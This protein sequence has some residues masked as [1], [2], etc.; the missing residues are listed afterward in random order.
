MP[1]I[2]ILLAL[3]QSGSLDPVTDPAYGPDGRIAASI[4][5][6]IWVLSA[7]RSRWSQ[8]TDGP[9]WDRQPAWYRDGSAL[10]FVSDRSGSPDL[11]VLRLE[12]SGRPTEPPERLTTSPQWDHQPTAG[13]N[14]SIVFVRG[15][16]PA[17]RLWIRTADGVER[18]LTRE[19]GSAEAW[20]AF[21]PQGDRVAYVSQ[22]AGEW[23]LRIAWIGRDSSAT[24]V[25]DRPI[26]WPAWS[27][28]GERL[29]FSTNGRTPGL[30]VTD[31]RGNYVN[32]IAP[33]AAQS[34]WSPDGKTLV[35]AKLAPPPPG[36]NG[37]PDRFG[38]RFTGELESEGSLAWVPAPAPPES[39]TEIA[40]PPR[41]EGT[42]RNLENFE[43]FWD[44][45]A[46]LYYSGR[47]REPLERWTALKEKYLPKARAASSESEL[48]SVFYAMLKERPHYRTPARGR[49]AV[50]SAHPVATAAGLEILEKGG[51]AVDAAVAVSFALGVVEPDASGIGGYGQMLI[52]L[53]GAPEPVLIEF[54]ARAPEEAGLLNAALTENGDYPDDGPVLANVPGLVAGM[55]LA[56]RRYGSGKL[57][58]EELLEPAIRAAERG[59]EV[60]DAL[61]TT[62]FLEQEHFRKY[63]ASR[64]LFLPGDRPLA[65]GDTLKNPDLAATLRRIAAG[66]AA[67]FY[68][69][70]TARKL[71]ADLRGQGNAIRLED[72]ARYYAAVRPA[73]GTTYRGYR[74]FSSAPP[75]SGGATLAAQ[76]NHL[77]HYSVARLFTE[78]AGTLHAM[79]EAWKLVPPGRGRI[80]D[81]GLWPVDLES[82]LSKDS[83][84]ARWGCFDPGRALSSQR[85]EAAR[86]GCSEPAAESERDGSPELAGVRAAG[87]GA[88]EEGDCMLA[89]HCHQDGTTAFAVADRYGNVVSVT[90]TLG[91]WGGNFY[92]TPGLGFLYNDKL[93]SY[94]SQRDAF[95]ARVPLARHGSSI[96]PTVVYGPG[97]RVWGL[98]AAGNAWI[99]AAVY[100][101]VVGIVDYRLSVQEAIE[102]PRFLLVRSG[103]GGGGTRSAAGVDFIVQY[104]DGLAPSVVQGLR[105]LGHS[106]QPISYPGELRMGYAAA[107]EAGEGFAVAGADPRRSGVAGAVP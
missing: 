17:A 101:M 51:N 97:G 87:M 19:R 16:G 48:R 78:D 13:P 61:A 21:S 103:G 28:D 75:A 44:R 52:A 20:P 37:D 73:V 23:E 91:T 42:D 79:I 46:R 14:G 58:W 1:K 29:S 54:M 6:D 31:L 35:V 86:D 59:F 84:A 53:K 90:Q 89:A 88:D 12:A 96:A 74:V 72:M 38:G 5:G 66:G 39:G 25:G 45:I 64:T 94:P 81:P 18:R 55:E 22:R 65:P 71:V 15:R 104:E 105:R 76:L 32:L 36:Y 60:S 7:D 49:A 95:G 82:F 43:R 24:V 40:L 107:V 30:W 62:I 34:S 102:L 47:N 33:Y 93:G 99:T 11:W 4:A 26:E 41:P 57:K 50:S 70:E 63:P 3:V 56:W 80:A 2:A 8:L 100:A 98:G 85:A 106:L 67:E 10:V 77:E 27:P 68:R 92:V 9:A 69:G 83:A